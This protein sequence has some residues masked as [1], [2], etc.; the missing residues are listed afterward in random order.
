MKLGGRAL[1]WGLVGAGVVLGFHAE[2]PRPLD[3]PRHGADVVLA[4]DFHVHSFPGDGALAPWDLAVEAQRRGLDAIALTNH[5]HRVSWSIAQMMPFHRAGAL[6]IPSEELTSAAYHMAAVGTS[7]NV[8]WHQS[9]AAA[10]AG[11]HDRGGVAIAAHPAGDD[12]KGFDDAALDALDGVEAAHP[13]MYAVRN[14][15]RDL[16][17]FYERARGRK[18]RIAAIGSTDF[19]F[20]APVGFCR[21]FVFARERSI[22]GVLD[23]IRRG[24]TVACDASGTTFGPADL[25]AAVAGACRAAAGAPA[26]DSAWTDPASALCVWLGLFGLVL[27]GSHEAA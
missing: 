8:P 17:A 10:A 2:T 1:A 26:R 16:A 13:L 7:G 3:P 12:A 23:A 4:A 14:G 9:A 11:I 21:T 15:R 25:S 27:L 5:N 19:H 24:A 18:P 20:F 22:D 6:L